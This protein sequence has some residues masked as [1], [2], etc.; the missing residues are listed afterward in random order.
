MAGHDNSVEPGKR[1]FNF[2]WYRPADQE[3][4]L[5]EL[6]ID[7]DGKSGTTAFCHR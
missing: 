6:Q 3:T 1:R 5:R 4:T 2:V 7:A